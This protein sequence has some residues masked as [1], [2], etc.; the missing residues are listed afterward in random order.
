MWTI[1]LKKI[2][3]LTFSIL[4]VFAVF[5]GPILAVKG[6][7]RS[8]SVEPQTID[9]LKG[10]T[11]TVKI[12]IRNV[13][14]GY[15]NNF[16]FLLSWDPSQIQYVSRTLTLVD[17]W[18][19]TSEDIDLDGYSF[20]ASGPL[21]NPDTSWVTITFRCLV[22]GT[23]QIMPET[24]VIF[25]DSIGQGCDVLPGTVNQYAVTVGG[26]SSPMNKLE[27]VAPYIAIAGL[28]AAVST[29]YVIKKRKD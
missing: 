27:I 15:M 6:Q 20:H 1:F 23:T 24:A 29:V 26:V 7:S 8:C 21:Y 17:G 10:D 25:V 19:L 13:D 3:S 2:I 18:S 16:Y 5:S 14:S 11:F 22:A 4:L 28:I 12:W 9:V